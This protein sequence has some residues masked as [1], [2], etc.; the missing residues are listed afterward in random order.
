MR[1]WLIFAKPCACNKNIE[2]A[3]CPEGMRRKN[4]K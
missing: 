1:V 4:E 3:L 2:V